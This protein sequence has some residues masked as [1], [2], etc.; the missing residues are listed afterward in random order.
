ML[1]KQNELKYSELPDYVKEQK[2]Q[3]RKNKGKVQTVNNLLKTDEDDR[4]GV[5][6][7]RF[8]VCKV[9]GKVFEQDYV[10]DRNAYQN[11]DT[12][13]SCRWK[14][15]LKSQNAYKEKAKESVVSTATIKYNPYPWQIKAREEFKKH[16]FN[17]WAMGNRCLL[18]GDF[19]QG[20]NKPIEELQEGDIVYN[21]NGQE[22]KVKYAG[23]NYYN[24]DVY[25]VRSMGCMDLICNSEHRVY[26]CV[27]NPKT[28]QI[29]KEEFIEVNK[30]QEYLNEHNNKNTKCYFK[31]PKIQKEIDCSEW[32]LEDGSKFPINEDTAWILGLYC[33]EGCFIAHSLKWTLDY[34]KPE[35]AK[36]VVDTL[37]ELGYHTSGRIR[38]DEGTHCVLTYKRVLTR[39]IDKEIGHGSYN[40][41]IPESILFN[42]NKNILISFLKGYYS[43][44]GWFDNNRQTLTATTVSKRLILE[45]QMAWNR[46]GYFARINTTIRKKNNNKEYT[47]SLV[48]VNGINLLGYNASKKHFH[49][50]AIKINDDIYVPI[51]KVSYEHK[52]C[53]IYNIETEDGTFVHNNQITGNSGKDFCANMIAIE[54]FVECLNENRYIEKPEMAPSVLWWI[55]APT[56]PMAKQN[57]RD[58]KKQFPKDWIVACSDSTFQMETIGGGIIE[59][60]SAYNPESLVGVGLDLVTITEAARIDYNKPGS[61]ALVWANL[62]ARLGSPG[63]GLDRDRKGKTYGVGKAIINS[64]PLGKNYFYE[65]FK[66]GQKGSDTYDSNWY[67]I[68]EPWTCNP[69]NQELAKS[70][71]KTK[72]GNMTYE[73]SLRRRLGDRKYRENYL[74]DF[75]AGDGS[76]FKEFEEKCVVNVFNLG[77]NEE[78]RKNFIADWQT[79]KAGHIYRIGYDP[80]TGSSGDDPAIVIRDKINNNIVWQESMYGKNYEQQWDRIAYLSRLYN[81]AECAW[82]RTGH[83]SIENQLSKRGVL[84]IPLDEQGG[85]KG[86]YVQSL[87]SAVQNG[88]VKVLA[89]GKE[90]SQ[91]LILQMNDYTEVN[92]KYS[93]NTM[94]HD[95]YVSAMYAAFYDFNIQ[96]E[97]N[98]YFCSLL[99]DF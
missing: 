37:E 46:L 29:I 89:D 93:N 83:T 84:E 23:F 2:K 87:E 20:C 49:Q 97:I 31:M 98:T 77:L 69:S 3:N 42:K 99:S 40:K 27:L 63:R 17:V 60:K 67:S 13:H 14:L 9:C 78:E 12:C 66:W 71:V 11:F 51:Q 16:R 10:P 4:T 62:E 79:P 88:I 74:A 82:L 86:E 41:C 94:E 52:D 57:W 45:L 73:E 55:I 39:R 19:I 91:T 32:I 92:K 24:G 6:G 1:K 47:I 96:G 59:V 26:I 68:Q 54:Y 81:Y 65:M 15:A 7:E 95:D 80:A 43:G 25:T 72:Y 22:Q 21:Q 30:L 75:L 34:K 53:K 58:L 90:E 28:K 76:V 85:K 44:D 33:A 56:E 18:E 61:L 50:Q 8:S 5:S 70:I 35:L 38:P 36:K 64:S 48:D